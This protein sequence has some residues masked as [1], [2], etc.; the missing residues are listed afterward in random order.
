MIAAFA[1]AHVNLAFS[2]VETLLEGNSYNLS[3]AD[4]FLFLGFDS[5]YLLRGPL[6]SPKSLKR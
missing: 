2:V 6:K 1:L 5:L 3:N 4:I